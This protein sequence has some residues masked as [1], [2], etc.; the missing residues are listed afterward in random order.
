MHCGFA[1]LD[2]ENEKLQNKHSADFC[3]VHLYLE[4]CVKVDAGFIKGEY[5]KCTVSFGYSKFQILVEQCHS[6]SS[7]FLFLFTRTVLWCWCSL[8]HFCQ[9]L[10][11]VY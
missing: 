5:T 9:I 10:V 11:S 3:R 1:A 6:V 2:W 4:I 7:G 8:K